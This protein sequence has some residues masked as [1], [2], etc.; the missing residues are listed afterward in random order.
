VKKVLVIGSGGSGK[1]TVARRLGELLHI[2]VIHLD[3]FYWQPGWI[4]T[5]KAEWLRIVD[6]LLKQDSWI[7]DG[8]YSGSLERRLESCDT[9]I[10]LDLPRSICTWR[11]LKRA[12]IYRK[13][14]RPDMA[15][16][17]DERFDPE[18]IRWVWNYSKRSKPK[19]LARLAAYAGQK[20][21][22]TLRSRYEVE[23]F[24]A[25]SY[26]SSER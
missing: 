13:S 3:N 12:I 14:K 20:R 21:I 10:F 23:K 6:A 16:G 17:C 18:F 26:S 25:D 9:V 4:E 1:S 11:V 22:V 15:V 19:V 2:E 5:P 24:F 7:M 8:N